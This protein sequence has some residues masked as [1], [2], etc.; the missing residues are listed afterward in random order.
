M[1]MIISKKCLIHFKVNSNLMAVTTILLSQMSMEETLRV[2][3]VEQQ[4]AVQMRTKKIQ[5]L[6]LMTPWLMNLRLN[7]YSKTT[8]MKSI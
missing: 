6:T 4:E 3:L 5:C 8:L 7:R 1:K 2:K